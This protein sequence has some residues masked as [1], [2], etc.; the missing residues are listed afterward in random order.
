MFDPDEANIPFEH[1]VAFLLPPNG[2]QVLS[3]KTQFSHREGFQLH[4]FVTALV[5][6][7]PIKTGTLNLVSRVRRVGDSDWISQSY[8][9]PVLVNE[10]STDVNE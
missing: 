5:G 10:P 9:L 7:P 6:L 3:S 8:P 1:E 4:R 2:E